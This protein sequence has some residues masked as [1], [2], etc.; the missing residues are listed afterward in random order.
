MRFLFGVP[1]VACVLALAGCQSTPSKPVPLTGPISAFLTQVKEANA[2][3]SVTK[4]VVQAGGWKEDQV[5]AKPNV[6]HELALLNKADLSYNALMAN[7]TYNVTGNTDVYE[8]QDARLETE[9]LRIEHDAAHRITAIEA[10]MQQRNYLYEQRTK[11]RLEISYHGQQPL[12][13]HSEFSGSQKMVV[14]R[15]FTY[16][17][18]QQWK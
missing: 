2:G 6:A 14:G 3:R 4:H 8:S 10:T 11:G 18:D 12:L 5:I 15:A 7:Y 16:H 17:I 9:S 1:A 13:T